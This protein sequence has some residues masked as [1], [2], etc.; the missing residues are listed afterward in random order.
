MNQD[1]YWEHVTDAASVA[2][3]HN[4]DDLPSTISAESV[5]ENSSLLDFKS[6]AREYPEKLFPLLRNLRVEFQEIFIEYYL[7]EKSQYFIGPTHGF[8]QTRVWQTLRTIEQAIGAMIVLGTNPG[9]DILRP[10]LFKAGVETTKYG[11]LT[12]MILLYANTQSYAAVAKQFGSPVP[13]VRKVFRPIIAQLLESKNLKDA[14]VGSYLRSLTHQASLTGTGLSKRCRARL[15]RVRKFKFDAPPSD[16]SPL[17]NFGPIAS[18]RDTPWTMLEISS[19]HRMTQ[20]FP[21]LQQ[22]GSRLFKKK[23]A[24]IFAPL[25]AN[26]ELEFGYILARTNP[27]ALARSLTRIRGISEMSGMYSNE[28]ALLEA[29]T[30]PHEDVQK[31]IDKHNAPTR[32]RIAVNQFVEILTGDAARYCGIVTEVDG[33]DIKVE[34]AF[35]S[36]RRFLVDAHATALKT[37]NV[38]ADKRAF[39]GQKF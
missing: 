20:I 15:S 9:A 35:P 8:I 16:E 2:A 21:L 12:D 25:D 13:A 14:A 22:Q 34:V 4:D 5:A 11:S 10:I 32:S 17:L 24:Q 6:F 37:L 36:G 33:A 27:P 38:P 19:E 7:L 31:I 3:F 30:V 23:A 29:I 18:L 39:W 26:G 28:G 1:T